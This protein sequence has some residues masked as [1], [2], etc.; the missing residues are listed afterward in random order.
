[1]YFIS[2]PFGN[3]LQYTNFVSDDKVISVT[4]TFTV[5][6]RPGLVK[7]TMGKYFMK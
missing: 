3:Y 7:Q 5:K 1:M 6:P 2:A 4:G